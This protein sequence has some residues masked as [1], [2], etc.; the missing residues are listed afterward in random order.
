MRA[1]W[2]FWTIAATVAILAVLVLVIPTVVS[3]WLLNQA[4]A[5]IAHAVALPVNAPDRTAALADA[6]AMLGRTDPSAVPRAT[7]A[8]ARLAL[9]RGDAEGASATL[10]SGRIPAASLDSIVEYVWGEAEWEAG[11]SDQAFNH[12][13]SAGAITYFM[14]EAHRATDADQWSMAADMARIAVGIDPNLADAHLVLGDAL[15]RL[16][17]TAEATDELE[18]ASSLTTDP[19]LGST[20]WSRLGEIR[21]EHGDYAGAL[22]LFDRARHLAP[23]DARPRTGYALV[24][25]QS[26]PAARAEAVALL[27]QVVADSPWYTAA[28]IALAD[29]AESSGDFR[30]AEEWLQKGLAKNPNDARLLYPLGL[31]YARQ[32]RWSEAK[33]E[34][35][36][37]LFYETRADARQSITRSLA[38]LPSP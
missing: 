34:L 5:Q 36:Q 21:A 11:R 29:Q 1:R 3:A 26:Q 12:W 33:T 38:E 14:Q 37:A 19:E 32:K 30:S 27:E 23:M 17:E 7:L 9:A 20:I 10:D 2:V 31:L 18:R 4:N 22:T 6:E 16:G 15:S 13:R 25:L 28:Y 24:L 8:E 35:D